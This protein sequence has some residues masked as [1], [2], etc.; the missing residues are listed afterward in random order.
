MFPSTLSSFS[1][2]NPSDRL[3]NPSH[4]ALHNTVSSALGQVEAVIGVD[5]AVDPFATGTIISDLRSPSS[6]GGGHIQQTNTGGTGYTSYNKGDLLVAQSA[7]LLAK[8]AIS[9]TA[10]DVLTVDPAQAVGMKWTG[11][12]SGAKIA[13]NTGTS[14]IYNSSTEQVL[15]A[16][17]ILGSTLGTNNGVKFYG[18][19]RYNN[20]NATFTVRG[21]YGVNSIFTISVP[22]VGNAVSS[23]FGFIQ[24]TIVGNTSVAQQKA[25]GEFYATNP[26]VELINQAAVGYTKTGG[27][28]F[29][30]SSVESSATQNL[31]ITGQF[32]SG[33]PANSV[34]G[35]FFTVEKIV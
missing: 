35:Q 22:Q 29:G 12:P 25:L 23:L 14:S 34:L 4:S 2:P 19:L 7:S 24:G 31:V 30:T 18:A 5:I 6:G 27:M 1:R 21:K 9:S 28:A 3:N 13:I 26:G 33:D 32:G 11:A 10:G 17:S 16:A 20:A 8:L 15:F